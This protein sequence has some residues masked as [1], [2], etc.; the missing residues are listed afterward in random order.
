MFSQIR[1]NEIFATHRKNNH[2]SI[3]PIFEIF[4]IEQI[5]ESQKKPNGKI[6][7]MINC[8]DLTPLKCVMRLNFN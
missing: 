3:K 6:A 1:P 2:Q 4:Q 8:M 5:F 7:F